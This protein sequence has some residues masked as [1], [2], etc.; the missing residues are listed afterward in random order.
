MFTEKPFFFR[1]DSDPLFGVLYRPEGQDSGNH[2]PRRGLVVCDSLFEEKF[3]CE[4]VFANMGRTL[5]QK[6][7]T[8]LIFDYFGYANSS[9]RSEDLSGQGILRDINDACDLIRGEGVDSIGILG[10]RWGAVPACRVASKRPD[11]SSLFLVKPITEWRKQLM[12]SLRANVAGQ[13]AIFKK[14]V[15]TREDIINKLERGG[16]CTSAGYRMNNIEGYLFSAEFWRESSDMVL[17]ESLPGHLSGN[18]VFHIPEREGKPPAAESKIV[19]I[20]RENGTECELVDIQE[21]NA[22]WLNNRIFTSTAPS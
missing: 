11:I 17:P 5:A 8:V 7:I 14:A 1:T 6:G 19:D 16:E 12:Q 9:G 4:R 21:D 10:I 15:M 13:Y 22:F 2:L 20:F 18:A 3:W